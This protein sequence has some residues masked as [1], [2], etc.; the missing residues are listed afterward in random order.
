MVLGFLPLLQKLEPS[1]QELQRINLGGGEGNIF[2][3]PWLLQ[4]SLIGITASSQIA[5]VDHVA[6]MDGLRNDAPCAQFGW[7]A[8]AT[9]VWQNPRALQRL[10]FHGIDVNATDFVGR[11]L[12][13]YAAWRGSFD[14][15]QIRLSW[16]ADPLKRDLWGMQA[17][18]LAL[19]QWKLYP[20][21]L[22]LPIVSDNQ[23]EQEIV[24]R[25]DPIRSRICQYISYDIA[26]ST[27]GFICQEFTFKAQCDLNKPQ[28]PEQDGYKCCWCW[29][30]PSTFT[31]SCA[32][33]RINTIITYDG[34][35]LDTSFLATPQNFAKLQLARIRRAWVFPAGNI[36]SHTGLM[37]FCYRHNGIRQ[38][39]VG[40]VSYNTEENYDPTRR[41]WDAYTDLD[42]QADLRLYSRSLMWRNQPRSF[43]PQITSSRLKFLR[44]LV[45]DSELFHWPT[46]Q[47]FIHI[48]AR[49]V[50]QAL[51]ILDPGIVDCWV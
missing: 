35:C 21:A 43:L 14:V 1:A 13:F 44:S 8:L 2:Q 27:Y 26:R 45:A 49:D 33:H 9:F 46:H 23:Y 36:P 15:V 50:M 31:L 17:T 12:L 30:I 24:L 19:L 34:S 3:Q 25:L 7:L 18:E 11:T 28:P 38:I 22:E 6:K 16:G 4:S 42:R 47:R 39:D 10:L 41:V 40:A 51:K 29:C 5:L 48:A 32:L 20:Q 37:G